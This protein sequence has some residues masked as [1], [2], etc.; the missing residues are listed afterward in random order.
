MAGYDAAWRSFT[1]DGNL[2][3]G[4]TYTTTVLFTPPGPYST[5]ETPSEGIDFFAQ[6]PDVPSSYDSF[7]HQ[8]LGIYL[9]PKPSGPTFDVSIH[10]TLSDEHPKVNLQIPLPFTGTASSPQAVTIS[11]TQLAQGNWILT[12]VSGATTLTLTSQQYGATWNTAQGLDGVRYFTSQG[13]TNPGGPL[14]WKDTSVSAV[15]PG[16]KP[17]VKDFNGNGYDDLVLE[18]TATGERLIWLLNNGAYSSTLSTLPTAAPS[19]HI[20]GVGDFL[21]NGQPDLVLEKS[22]T[23]EHVIWILNN[24]VLQYGIEV[25]PM[26]SGWRVVGAGDFDGDGNA[27]LVCENSGTG[28]RVIWLMKQGVYSSSIA[29]PTSGPAWHVVGVGDFLGNGESD[30][31]L[32][33]LVTNEHVIC[34]LNN[35]VLD[36]G[37]E[38]KPMSAGWHVAGVGDFNGDGNADLVLQNANG[39]RVIWLLQ[40]GVYS[41]SISLPTGSSN[42]WQIADH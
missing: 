39:Q 11:F 28:Q 40:N 37:I 27:D 19:W 29:L 1:G 42:Q 2:Y 32:E 20:V 25:K 9:G 26:S 12:M 16:S 14:E 18:N 31:I 13:G 10:T 35:G 36:H 38:L 22:V 8:V 15:P 17:V 30:L 33:N 4:Q 3:P 5:T 24:G 7:G 23:N 34:I 21:G 41:S 6:D